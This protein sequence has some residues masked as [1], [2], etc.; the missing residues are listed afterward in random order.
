MVAAKAGKVQVREAASEV[1]NLFQCMA[2]S[3]DLALQYIQ[4]DFVHERQDDK[5]VS[6]D[7]LI[8]RMTIARLLSL[9]LQESEMTID[10]WERAKAL[11]GRRK[12][13]A[14]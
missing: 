12:A 10:V 13:R 2:S 6:T 1:S 5:N 11:D 9:S 8:M 3:D 4:N 7:D 14:F